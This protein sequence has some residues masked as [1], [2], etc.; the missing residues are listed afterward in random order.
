MGANEV[1]YFRE[2]VLR[3]CANLKE[4]EPSCM[5]LSVNVE[6]DPSSNRRTTSRSDVNR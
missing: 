4:K 5:M 3:I 6:I 2:L 1:K